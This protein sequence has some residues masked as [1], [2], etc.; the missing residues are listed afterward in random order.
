VRKMSE[1]EIDG[2]ET[3]LIF[4]CFPQFR[5]DYDGLESAGVFHRIG[6]D[7]YDWQKSKTSLAEYFYSI[8]SNTRN[9]KGGFWE[10]VR[11]SF[12][13]KTKKIGKNDLTKARSKQGATGIDSK[14]FK[15][16]KEIIDNYQKRYNDEFLETKKTLGHIKSIITKSEKDPPELVME[17]YE[18][19][20]HI[21]LG[22]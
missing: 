5:E 22:G 16:I 11:T 7:C 20:K 6:L 14:D 21:F 13:V 15:E 3:E 17:T 1:K 12:T 9:T 4:K 18:Q 10:P 8:G 19:I 2:S